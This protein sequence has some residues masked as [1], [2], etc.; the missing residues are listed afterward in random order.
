ME[1]LKQPRSTI[2]IEDEMRQSYL[3][4]AMSVI[5][6]RAL[7]DARDGLKPVHRRVLYAMYDLSNDWN[8]PYKKSARV[9]GDVIGKYH[10]HGDTAVYDA[11]ARMAQDFSLRY[12]LID[13]QGNFGSIDGDPPAAM[14]YTEVRMARIASELLADIEKDTVEFQPNYDDTLR[15]PLALPA[16]IPNLLINGSAGIAVGMATN[17]PPHNLGEIVDAAMMLI[18]RPAVTIEELIARVPGPDFPTGGILC[19]REAIHEAYREGRGILTVRARATVERE[20][21]S[22]RES[23]VVSEIPFQV[24]K[25]RLIERIAELVNEKTIEGISDL[26]D[27]SDREGMR[28]VIEL[29]RDAIADIVLNQLYRHTPMQ[30]S[31]GVNMLAIVDGRPRVLNLKSALEVFL[32]HRRDVVRRRT[33][34]ELR[35]A[36]KRLHVLAGFAIALDHLD[37]VIVLIRGAVDPSAAKQQLMSRFGLSEIQAQEILNLR[38]QRLTALER[39]KILAELAET[40]AQIRR[41][42]EILADEREV[43]KIIVEE[44]AEVRK[45]YAD[46][47]R[48]EIQEEAS[49]F[50]AEDLI[51]EEDMV[52][53]ISHEGYV[54][55]NPVASYRA[56]RRGGRGKIGATTRD[57]DFVEHLFVASTHSHILF[58]TSTGRV[59]WLKVHEIPLIGRA[60]RGKPL[61]NLLQL[62]A[63]EKISAILPMREFREG[64]YLCFATRRGLIKKTDV[65]AYSNPRPSGLIAIALEEGD[66]V[67]DVRETDGQREIILS[68]RGGQAIRFPETGARAMGRGTYGVKGITLED[69]DAVVAMAIVDPAA[70]L[71]AVSALGSGKRTEMEEYRVTRRGGKGII[72]M[73]VTEKTGPVVG[74]L[75]VTDDD[76][77]M[78]ITTGGKLIRLHVSEV[79]QSGRNTQGVRLIGLEPGEQVVAIARLAEAEEAEAGDDGNGGNGGGEEADG[80]PI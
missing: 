24:N 23:I 66:E 37:E 69:G 53:T 57:E 15:E 25:A 64:R 41:Y 67:I 50:T 46:P 29:K 3:D 55:R 44:L 63:E 7:P 61:V 13:G 78:L 27:E 52:V 28:I 32:E 14:R 76:Q 74:V 11:I 17:I 49:A 79:R 1:E 54:K 56:Q 30:D 26:R 2:N 72:T 5:I 68:T 48:T 36:E 58:F 18:E 73:R 9:V 60:A 71:L 31:F 45:L 77:I 42:R 51:A 12:P 40:E 8:R 38:L 16:K 21:K 10:P 59:Y 47:R 62:G 75:I 33:A 35:E 43:D 80:D 4:Y 65:M 39:D 34:F 22:E 20:A 6:G 70:S 19:G